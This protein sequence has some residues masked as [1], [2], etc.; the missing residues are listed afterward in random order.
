MRRM[1]S[2]LVAVLLGLSLLLGSVA[3]AGVLTRPDAKTTKATVAFHVRGTVRG[4]S[5]GRLRMMKVTVRNT[6]SRRLRVTR[7]TA[8]VVRSAPSCPT[9]AIRVKPWRG[10]LLVRPGASRKVLLKV[11]MKPTAP[12]ACQ[13][14]RFRLRYQGKA[15]VR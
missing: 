4:L 1:R 5:P 7:I 12:N 15:T 14:A 10:K 11:R 2:P 8:T 13:G 9:T 6:S 3:L